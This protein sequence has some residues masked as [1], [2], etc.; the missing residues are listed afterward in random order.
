MSFINLDIA[1]LLS[2][3][4]RGEN[5][6]SNSRFISSSNLKLPKGFYP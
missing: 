3:H 2:K 1:Y 5:N 6:P 4:E